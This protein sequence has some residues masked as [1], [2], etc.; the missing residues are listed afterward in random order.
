MDNTDG[1][2]NYYDKKCKHNNLKELNESNTELYIDNT[3]YKYKK[4]FKPEKEGIYSIKLKF[5]N[6]SIKDCS[7]MFCDCNNIIGIDL[8]FFIIKILLIWRVCLTVV[9]H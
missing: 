7:F 5:K 6:I 9:F 1:I 2:Y 8:Y 4:Y 3:N